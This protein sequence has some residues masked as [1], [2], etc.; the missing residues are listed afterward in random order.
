MSTVIHETGRGKEETKKSLEDFS[1]DIQEQVKQ[2]LEELIDKIVEDAI[3]LCPKDTGSLASSIQKGE[4]GVL[5]AGEPNTFMDVI[6]SAGDPSIVNPKTGKS[7]D[8]YVNYVHDGHPFK[9]GKGYYLGVP[10]LVEALL[11]NEDAIEELIDK[12]LQD[13]A[14]R[15][16]L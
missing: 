16:D 8:E 9:G 3:A 4:G 5:T 10:F 1:E 2:E 15:S 13:L 12:A 7:T 11:F 6:I 14:R